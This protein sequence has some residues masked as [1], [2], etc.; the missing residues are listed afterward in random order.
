MSFEELAYWNQWHEVIA[1]AE[2]DVV[3]KAQE[4]GKR[5]R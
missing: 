2:K 4:S 1:K 3:K 5:R